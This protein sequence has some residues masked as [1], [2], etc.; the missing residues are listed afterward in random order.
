MKK[1][2]LSI[3][4]S[5]MLALGACSTA[6]QAKTT[7]TLAMLQVQVQQGCMVV[8]PTLQAVAVLDPAVAAAATANGLFCAAAGSI[9]V[10]SIQS[11]IG[12]GI[13]AIEQAV[14]AST[15]IPANEKPAIMAGLGIFQLTVT[16][17]FAAYGASLP[18]APAVGA[19]S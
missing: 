17:A 6:E 11:L 10:T 3:A 14:T 12:T 16:N 2:A 4:I 1:L 13:P 5:S 7:E 19:S 15:A 8:Q 18:A 9:T